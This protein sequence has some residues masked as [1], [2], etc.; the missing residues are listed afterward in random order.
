MESL[1]ILKT[2]ID[3]HI[4]SFSSKANRD[5]GKTF[6]F[7]LAT[8]TLTLIATLA[9]GIE[10]GEENKVLMK[11][12]AFVCSA[13]V[14]FLTGL[15]LYYN[16]KGLWVQYVKT[17]NQLYALKY[18]IKISEAHEKDL[19]EDL[20]KEF[21]QKLE[22]ILEECNKWWLKERSREDA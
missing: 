5:K 9:L 21:S 12:A 8:L 6:R 20:V 17:R 7:K 2:E 15:D 14:T 13:F 11:N 18:E 22:R 19:N 16:H 1:K 3:S 4:E 10:F